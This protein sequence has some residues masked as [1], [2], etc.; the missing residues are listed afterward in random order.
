M[1]ISSS[2]FSIKDF[3]NKH[4]EGDVAMYK[5]YETVQKHHEHDIKLIMLTVPLAYC[6]THAHIE[7]IPPLPNYL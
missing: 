1:R 6:C 7:N 3:V 4:S 2:S 5:S